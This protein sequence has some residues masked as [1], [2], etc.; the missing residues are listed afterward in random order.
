[1]AFWGL[2]EPLLHPDIVEMVALAEELG[3]RTELI[4]NGL[5]LDQEMAEGL[6]QAGLDTL[7]ISVDGASPEAHAGIRAGADLRLVQQNVGHPAGPAAHEPS[8]QSGDWPGVRGHTAQP[9][10]AAATCDAWPTR[11]RPALSS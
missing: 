7:V 6:V 2:G 11:W 10:G 4:T 5:L 1:M 9:V 8:R 3:A